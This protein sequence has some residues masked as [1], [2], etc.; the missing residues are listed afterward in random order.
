MSYYAQARSLRH[1]VM[2]RDNETLFDESGQTLVLQL[3][4]AQTCLAS[5]TRDAEL[6]QETKSML[7]AYVELHETH[8]VAPSRALRRQIHR[9][10]ADADVAAQGVAS[11][12]FLGCEPFRTPQRRQTHFARQRAVS[13]QARRARNSMRS[14]GV[15]GNPRPR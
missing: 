4:K 9:A 8:D 12:Y 7:D 11:P 13:R 5:R 1:A 3:A 15:I 6:A 14:G 10:Q 2:K